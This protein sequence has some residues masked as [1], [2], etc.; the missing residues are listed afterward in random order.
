MQHFCIDGIIDWDTLV[1]FNSSVEF[2]EKE[3]IKS[4]D[5]SGR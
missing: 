4:L 2:P 5:K 1:K 3:L